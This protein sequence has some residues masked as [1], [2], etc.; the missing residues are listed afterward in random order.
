M[1]H[2]DRH[3]RDQIAATWGEAAH[4]SPAAAT[5]GAV[6]RLKKYR[7]N[8]MKKVGAWVSVVFGV[9][10]LLATF[11]T[12]ADQEGFDV[13]RDILGSTVLAA[14]LALPGMYWLV[15]NRQDQAAVQ[16][17]LEREKAN[18]QLAGLLVGGE[19]DLLSNRDRAP[20]LP[21][22]RWK[23]IILTSFALFI[24]SGV[25]LPTVTS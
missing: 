2:D 25:F 15:R 3:L 14:A 7:P 13:V 12:A 8:L 17:W 10:I 23:A 20:L 16:G 24:L 5:E 11:G 21:K 1:T 22:R 6:E 18:D 4:Q 9:M 19:R